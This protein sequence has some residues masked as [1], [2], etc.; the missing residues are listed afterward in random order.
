VRGKRVLLIPGDGSSL[1]PQ[2][3]AGLAT[4][5]YAT[6]TAPDVDAGLRM[7]A[8]ETYDAIVVEAMRSA[9]GCLIAHVLHTRWRTPIMLIGHSA[10]EQ[11][12]INGYRAG[13]DAYLGV[14]CDMQELVARMEGLLRRAELNVQACRTQSFLQPNYGRA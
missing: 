2:I 12:E 11:A 7:L 5:G 13:A 9:D 3:A 10:D 8:K 4:L 14:P 1:T 6:D